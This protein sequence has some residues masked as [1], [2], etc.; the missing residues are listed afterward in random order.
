MSAGFAADRLFLTEPDTKLVFEEH[1]T[2]TASSQPIDDQASADRSAPA[3][4][5]ATAEPTPPL[6]RI[7]RPAAQ[8]RRSATPSKAPSQGTA[9]NSGGGAEA[10]VAQLTNRERSKAGCGPL[11]VDARLRT[12]ARRHSADMAARDYFSHDSPSG[13]TFVDRIKAAGYLSPGAENIAKGHPTAAAVV[14]GWMK[15]PGHRANIL[16]CD[17]RAIGVGAHF[18]AGGPWWTQDFGW[19]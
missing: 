7:Q 9:S 8:S 4:P 19:E 14:A 18:A 12:A 16:N 17:L 2:G 5:Q 13:S 1:S 15:S 6:K 3:S 10:T 11:R